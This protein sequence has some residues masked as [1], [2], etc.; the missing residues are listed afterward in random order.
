M[1]KLFYV[2]RKNITSEILDFIEVGKHIVIGGTQYE[3]IS[4]RPRG[5]R[6]LKKLSTPDGN[7]KITIYA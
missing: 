6:I 5:R 4:K 3:R 2:S 7:E 1:E